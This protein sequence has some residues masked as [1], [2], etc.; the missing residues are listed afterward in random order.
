[1]GRA[2]SVCRFA[3]D[4]HKYGL[5]CTTTDLAWGPLF[6]TPE[7]ACAWRDA[8]GSNDLGEC[9]EAELE[10]VEAVLVW[11]YPDQYQKPELLDESDAFSTYASRG[12]MRITGEVNPD[13]PER[14]DD[15]LSILHRGPSEEELAEELARDTRDERADKNAEANA[16]TKPVHATFMAYPYAEVLAA[17]AAAQGG[18]ATPLQIQLA[19]E[20]REVVGA[21]TNLQPMEGNE[22]VFCCEEVIELTYGADCFDHLFKAFIIGGAIGGEPVALSV[23]LEDAGNF[24]DFAQFREQI[25]AFAR[26]ADCE[27]E[28]SLHGLVP[29]NHACR[30]PCEEAW[31]TPANQIARQ[32]LR[33][34]Y[35]DE[36]GKARKESETLAA[37]VAEVE[38]IIGRQRAE[39]E[40][41]QIAAEI[42]K[43][44][45]A[46]P[47]PP[48][49][50]RG[51]RRV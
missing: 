9:P 46:T 7:A 23:A 4:T 19:R 36:S 26:D 15:C 48:V 21:G 16:G 34:T 24:V 29:L 11:P 22:F 30:V 27:S 43:A 6:H 12:A 13:G 35:L 39:S 3:D 5:F 1:M 31:H 25:P 41:R 50:S 14:M 42:K 33:A 37:V 10:N 44:E 8:L 17:Q 18:K 38:Y 32:L 2:L 45:T 20:L 47:S 49:P 40:A 51:P 28:R